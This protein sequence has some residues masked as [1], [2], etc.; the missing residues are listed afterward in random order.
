[1]LRN[2]GEHNK[3][4]L[5]YGHKSPQIHHSHVFNA[6]IQIYTYLQTNMLHIFEL[7]ICKKLAHL[8]IT[9][10][11]GGFFYRAHWLP[12]HSN[13]AAYTESAAHLRTTRHGRIDKIYMR[14][15]V[16]VPL[17]C[18]AVRRRH[19]M[20]TAA[21]GDPCNFI[22]LHMLFIYKLYWSPPHT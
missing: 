17:K 5:S 16:C 7:N 8:L 9:I 18:Q 12:S 3:M 15:F 11:C 21:A 10:I 2:R 4:D 1:M 6:N 14:R 19:G 13:S 20:A 22:I